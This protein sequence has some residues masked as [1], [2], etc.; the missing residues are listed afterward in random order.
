[1]ESTFAHP[2]RKG[3]RGYAY[4]LR[5]VS[6]DGMSCEITILML[7]PRKKSWNAHD[8]KSLIIRQNFNK[9]AKIDK[10]TKGE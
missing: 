6:H 4:T 10:A 7:T 8:G 2:T 1:M 9:A 5:K 3:L